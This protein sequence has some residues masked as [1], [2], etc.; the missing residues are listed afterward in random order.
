MSLSGPQAL[1]SLEEALR[2]VRREEDEIARRLAKSNE[3]AAKFR[4]SEAD[5]FRQLAT[6]R[7]DPAAQTQLSDSISQVELRARERLK[8]HAGELAATEQALLGIDARIAELNGTRALRLAEIDRR[9]GEL[10]ALSSRIGDTIVKDPGYA[11]KLKAATELGDIAAESLEKTEQA[12]A[13]RESKGRPYRDDPLFMYLWDR[14]YGTS[15]YRAGN[16]V[17]YLDG[18]VA[19]LIGYLRARPNFA[20]LNEI[21]LRLREH[22]ERQAQNSAAARAQ[23]EALETAAIDAAGGKPIREALAAA[24]REIAAIDADLVTIEDERD[25]R[26]QRLRDLSQGNDPAFDDALT[27]LAQSLGREDLQTLLTEAR[28]TQTGQDDTIVAQIDDARARAREEGSQSADLK[29]RLK[30]LAARRRELEDIQFEFKKARFDDPRSTFR[31]DDLVGDLL[32]DFLRGGISAASYWDQW[33]S[34]QD[35]RP[36]TSEWGGGIGLPQN[37]RAANPWSDRGGGG[38]SWPDN[39]FGGGGR[40]GNNSSGNSSTG[41]FSGG[42]SWPKSSGTRGGGGGFSRPRTG[43]VGTRKHGGFKTGGGF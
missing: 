15:S 5:L 18:L 41:G 16:L 36:G 35:W 37:G 4:E 6:V 8:Q 24:Q 13:D 17:R 19:G 29:E 22:A 20:M 32:N 28:R 11:A 1:S 12:E 43:S 23:M 3:V 38:F 27:A 14:G 31:Q 10:K 30:T 42:F 33:R 40:S 26:A 21:P 7:L 2:D 34:S 9:Q 25:D 39:S